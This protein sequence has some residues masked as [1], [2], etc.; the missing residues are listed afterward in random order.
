MT[1]QHWIF[2]K[3]LL[4]LFTIRER[5][6]DTARTPRRKNCTRRQPVR[7]RTHRFLGLDGRAC[8]TRRVGVRNE[9]AGPVATRGRRLRR[10]RCPSP[11]FN[12]HARAAR[13]LFTYVDDNS[14]P[15]DNVVHKVAYFLP[16]SGWGQIGIKQ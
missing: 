3:L 16:R 11:R 1:T 10:R 14:P 2:R 8:A 5:H 7:E 13:T 9:T 12:A 15:A 4:L 6:T